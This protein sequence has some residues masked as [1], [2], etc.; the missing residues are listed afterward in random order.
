MLKGYY[1]LLNCLGMLNWKSVEC[2]Y[3]GLFLDSQFCFIDLLFLSFA[4]QH[5]LD[6]CGFLVSFEIRKCEFFIFLF[7]IAHS[8]FLAFSHEFL[9]LPHQ[10]SVKSSAILMRIVFSLWLHLGSIAILTMLSLIH[11]L[12][13]SFILFEDA[14]TFVFRI[15]L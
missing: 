13:M 11:E 14:I 10:V 3:E 15:Q 4:V 5:Y 1:C 2:N 9:G 8:V 6:Y 12:E 7:K